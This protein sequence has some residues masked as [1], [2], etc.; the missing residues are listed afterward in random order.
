MKMPLRRDYVLFVTVFVSG[1]TVLAVEMSASRLLSP[2]F[3]DSQLVWANLIGLIMIYLTVG[4]YVGGRL[5]DRYPRPALLY[6][7]AA[8]AGFS[9]GLIPFLSKPIL[10]YS[11]SGLE[12]YSV[13]IVIG[14]FLTILLL[15]TLPVVLLGCV[16]PFAIRLQSQSVVST[17]HTSGTIYALST[18][19]SILGT[20]LPTLVLIPLLGTGTTFLLCSLTLL[21]VS[22]AGLFHSIGPRAGWYL[23]LPFSIL[24]LRL[25]LPGGL[26]KPAEGLVYEKESFYNYIQVVDQQDRRV[27]MLNEGQALHSAYRP[28]QVLSGGVWDYFLLGPYFTALPVPE[29][30]E[31]VCMVGLAAGTAAKEYTAVYGPVSIRGVELDPEV[32]Q[33]G[34]RFFAMDEPN[35]SVIVQDGRYFLAQTEESY[36]VIVVDAYRQPYIPFHLTTREF[37]GLTRD[38]LNSGGAVVVNAGRTASDFR[39][40]DVLAAT[41]QE[42]FE[43]VFIVDVPG[44]SNSL[45][46]GTDQAT[47]LDQVRTRL[48]RSSNQ[49]LAGIA[50]QAAGRIRYADGP[51]MVLTDD[52]APVEHLTH[53]IILRYVLEG[54]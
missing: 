7:L 47:S 34:R 15:F 19:G 33:V 43:T 31:S 17:G 49:W 50:E 25:I 12:N 9:I 16:S 8:W 30:L 41:M 18:L 10:R 22:L 44:D 4:Y 52:R 3:G 28:G 46:I 39:L 14:S 53:L 48:L 54:E 38:R 40:V 51:G 32:V 23:V 1:M 27:L 21:L 36:D 13:E 20:F 5:A 2:Y 11:L 35:L 37:F 6:Q 45:V 42:V 24:L 29:E 26:V